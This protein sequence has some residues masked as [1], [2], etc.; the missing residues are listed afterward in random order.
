MLSFLLCMQIPIWLT[1]VFYRTTAAFGC[2]IL[3]NLPHLPFLRPL[4]IHLLRRPPRFLFLH[5][6]SLLTWSVAALLTSGR[7]RWTGQR[8][9]QSR[10]EVSS[11]FR[12]GLQ[13]TNELSRDVHSGL[14]GM[15]FVFYTRQVHD[16]GR[17]RCV[18][19]LKFYVLNCWLV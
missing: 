19:Q 3:M 13:K 10:K 12:D 18:S 9:W 14:S 15:Q 17:L 4:L 7:T 8:H 6:S 2:K 5:S 11:E 16:F 1:H